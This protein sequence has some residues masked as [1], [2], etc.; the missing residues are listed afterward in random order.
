MDKTNRAN[1]I[2]REF[3]DLVQIYTDLTG[4]VS[5]YNNTNY[6]LKNPNQKYWNPKNRNIRLFNI[7][8][9]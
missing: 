5:K 3:K 4:N 1:F 2:K 9:I 8:K 7:I 6:N